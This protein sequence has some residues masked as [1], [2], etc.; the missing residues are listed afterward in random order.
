MIQFNSFFKILL[1]TCFISFQFVDHCLNQKK[2]KCWIINDILTFL[3]Q[4]ID[5]FMFFCYN[6]LK[7]KELFFILCIT[8]FIKPTCL[9]QKSK[10]YKEIISSTV[11]ELDFLTWCLL[12]S[13]K[14]NGFFHT[15]QFFFIHFPSCVFFLE[16]LS[17]LFIF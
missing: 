14:I 11:S 8:F 9:V 5:L 17:I 6:I 13:S 10:N 7:S 12:H 3:L 4:R 15:T 16:F 1:F 2:D